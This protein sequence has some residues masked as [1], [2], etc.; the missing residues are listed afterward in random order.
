MSVGTRNI[1]MP[2]YA[3]TS[4]SVTTIT[5]MKRAVRAFDEKNLQPLI[6]HSSPSLTARVVNILGSAPACGSV[7]E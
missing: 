4:G 6:T 3:L 7:I 1:D 2:W 5:M